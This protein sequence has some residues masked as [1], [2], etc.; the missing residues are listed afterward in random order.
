MWRSATASK[1]LG[2][3]PWRRNRRRALPLLA[4]ATFALACQGD[5]GPRVPLSRLQSDAS[6][7]PSGH[8]P[9]EASASLSQTARTALES[10]NAA[11]RSKEFDRAL[12]FYLTAARAAPE[13]ASPW[14]G[15]YMVAEA[16]GNAALRDS[17]MREV[18]KRTVDP[19]SVTDSTLRNTHPAPPKRSTS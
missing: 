3:R 7:L 15:I 6:A 8:P 13:H 12:R 10:G 9:I 18:K 17:A 4:V 14:F 5:D 1:A 11:F 2:R 16:T 19:P